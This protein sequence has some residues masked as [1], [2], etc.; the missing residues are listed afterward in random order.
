MTISISNPFETSYFA[1][2]DQKFDKRLIRCIVLPGPADNNIS[3]T[4]K[5]ATF[6]IRETPHNNNTYITA[7]IHYIRVLYLKVETLYIIQCFY[8][9]GKFG[10][11]RLI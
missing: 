3:L 5:N 7:F 8:E 1:L 9:L 6:E 11:F 2:K 4:L 10:K